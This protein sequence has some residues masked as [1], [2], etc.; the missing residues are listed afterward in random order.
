MI[1]GWIFGVYKIFTDASLPFTDRAVCTIDRWSMGSSK[2]GS[3]SMKYG[4]QSMESQTLG[5]PLYNMTYLPVGYVYLA[6]YREPV[7]YSISNSTFSV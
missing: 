7:H 4:H 5:I 2:I 3:S 6:L 1:Y